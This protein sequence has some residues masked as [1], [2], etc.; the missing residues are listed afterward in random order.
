M[1]KI[2]TFVAALMVATMSFAEV[3]Y[4]LNGG[5]TNE[6]GWQNKQDMYASMNALWNAFAK[7]R[8]S[9]V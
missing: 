8:K 5:W 6:D 1:K 9:V 4:E 2:F 3:T 7:D